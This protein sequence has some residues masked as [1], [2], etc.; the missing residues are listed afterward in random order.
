MS[1]PAQIGKNEYNAALAKG[2]LA[3]RE[4]RGTLRRIMQES[5]S[6]LIRALAGSILLELSANDEALERLDEIG[7]KNLDK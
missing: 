3:N 7:R 4:V 2:R 5:N 6:N 1:T